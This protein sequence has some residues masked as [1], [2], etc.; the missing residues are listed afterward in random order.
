MLD[1]LSQPQGRKGPEVLAGFNENLYKK[2]VK[3]KTACYTFY[4][5]LASGMVLCGYNEEKQLEACRGICMELGE[6]F[7]IEDDYLDCYQDPEILG[8][9]GTDIQD[10]KCS[11]LCV[12]A[13]KRMNAKQREIFEANYGKHDPENVAIIKALYKELDLTAVYNAQED[14]SYKRI[15]GLIA[16]TP[17][18]PSD[19]FL[20]ILSKIHNRQR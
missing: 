6:K 18:L 4:L 14:D 17:T 8:K 11:W 1:L 3:Y 15:Q 20:P 19:L 13:L 9:I 5:P 2:I 16:A 10:H 7:Q 12:Q